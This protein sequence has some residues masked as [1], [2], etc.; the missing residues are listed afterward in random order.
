VAN[1]HPGCLVASYTY[2]SH[3]FDNK[4]RALVE[5]GTLDWRR[6][7]R[8]QLE[9]IEENRK[10][11]IEVELDTLADMLSSVIEG[12]IILSR[13]LNDKYV[14]VNQLKQYRNYL[15]L[16]YGDSLIEAP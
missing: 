16:L 1:A 8:E 2:A 9:R 14:L 10:P 12:G 4:I 13:V 3:L 15:R 5:S 11:A 6:I 7:F